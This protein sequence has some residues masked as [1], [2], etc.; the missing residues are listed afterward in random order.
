MQSKLYKV[1]IR[2]RRG[3]GRAERDKKEEAED[4]P[5]VPMVVIVCVWVASRAIPKSIFQISM[6]GKDIER[7]REG[8]GR[9]GGQ[10]QRGRVREAGEER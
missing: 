6:R 10:G 5:T 8:R 4:I 2:K 1:S 3:K 9:E 7:E